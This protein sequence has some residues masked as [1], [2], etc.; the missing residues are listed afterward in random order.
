MPFKKLCVCQ[1]RRDLDLFAYTFEGAEDALPADLGPWHPFSG[2]LRTVLE[3]SEISLVKRDGYLLKRADN[4]VAD[5]K[6]RY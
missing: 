1:S 6:R 4:K 2:S 3:V 5:F